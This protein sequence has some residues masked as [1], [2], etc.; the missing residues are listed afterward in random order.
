MRRSVNYLVVLSLC[1]KQIRGVGHTKG[2]LN[3]FD[4]NLDN[5]R[6][7]EQEIAEMCRKV[8]EWGVLG[9]REA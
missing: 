1:S 4:G 2:Q 7:V 3:Q 6:D 5:L 8:W 9:M